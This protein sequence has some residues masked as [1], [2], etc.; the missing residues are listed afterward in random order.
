MLMVVS[1]A[2]NLDWESEY[3]AHPWTKPEFLTD[4]GILAEKAKALS[5]ADI[6]E[7]MKLSEKLSELNHQR[8][9]DYQH[10]YSEGSARPAVFAFAGDVYQGMEPSSLGSD[11]LIWLNQHLRI[12]SGF[13]GLLRPFDLI[14]PYRLEMGRPL[15]TERGTNL[16]HFW[17][18]TLAESINEQLENAETKVLVNLASNEYFKS[19][20]LKTLQATVHTPQFLDRKNGQYKMISFYAKRARG[21]MARFV[22]THQIDQPD[23]L[24][25]FNLAGYRYSPDRS[26]PRMPTFI[27][28]E[29]S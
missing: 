12:L 7:L 10:P 23:G 1:P 28:D 5:A 18:S 20:P 19:V 8:F 9:Q 21:L 29:P 15:K 3:P 14:L 22:A 11:Q 24:L 13:Y 26:T 4:T 25:D 16:Y 27:R 6:G 17:G 2:K